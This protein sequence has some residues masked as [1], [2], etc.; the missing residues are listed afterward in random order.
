MIDSTTNKIIIPKEFK[1]ILMNINKISKEKNI[2]L[3]FIYLPEKN[4]FTNNLVNDLDYRQ[5]GKIKELVKSLNIPIIDL[6]LEFQKK[7]KDPLILYNKNYFHLNVLGYKS[8]GNIIS[9]KMEE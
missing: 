6:N 7:F 2:D 9:D 3:Y 4:R 1:K 5:Y 8:V